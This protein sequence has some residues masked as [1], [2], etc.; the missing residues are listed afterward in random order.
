VKD[1][2]ERLVTGVVGCPNPGP[3]CLRPSFYLF[4]SATPMM[5]LRLC[6]GAH[7]ALLQT[8]TFSSGNCLAEGG[9][10]P[11]GLK[12]QNKVHHGFPTPLVIS[13]VFF[14]QQVENTGDVFFNTWP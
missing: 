4:R 12:A 11:P 2:H 6:T 5:L 10:S 9:V 8:L 3:A 7:P 13:S 1:L 14:Q